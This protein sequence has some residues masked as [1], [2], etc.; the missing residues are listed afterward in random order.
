MK[1]YKVFAHQNKFI[2]SKAKYPALVAGYGSGKTVAFVLKAILEAGR[3]PQKT[4][5]L[6]EPTFPMIRDVLQP[7]LEDMLEELKFPY[8]YR[9]SEMKYTIIWKN[10]Y[11]NIIL[12]SAENFR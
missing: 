8:K 4:I 6:A 10:G 12:R 5:L 2:R 11:T 7:T 1:S 9:A 3:N